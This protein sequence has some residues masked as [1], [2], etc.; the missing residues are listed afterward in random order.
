MIICALGGL[1]TPIGDTPYTYLY[2]T[3][4]GNTTQNISE[5]FTNELLLKVQIQCVYNNYFK[6]IYF[7]QNKIKF[8]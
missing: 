7:L 3:M 1:L 6:Q 4:Q 5:L 2:K 8:I